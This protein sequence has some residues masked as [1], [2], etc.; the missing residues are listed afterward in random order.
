[1]SRP[2]FSAV[3]Q[4][5]ELFANSCGAGVFSPNVYTNPAA[6]IRA[7]V[8][9]EL[10]KDALNEYAYD[11][12]IS[13]LDYH[14]N[15]QSNGFNLEIDGY[16]D[17]MSVLLEKV[18]TKMRD[19]EVKPDRF[20]VIKDWIRRSYKNW[21]F[22]QPYSQIR[23][24]T[25]YLTTEKYWLNEEHLEELELLTEENIAAFIP[26]ALKQMHFEVLVHG[27]LFK[28]DA[29]KVGL[30]VESVFKP[31]ALPHTQFRERRSLLIPAGSRFIYQHR[32]KDPE[33][34][35]SCI[36]YT[37]WVGEITDR[38]LRAMVNLLSQIT[39]EYGFSF[40]PFFMFEILTHT[41]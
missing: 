41:S 22:A 28:E 18:L 20:K 29:L 11:A 35:N 19:L 36:D 31:R 32:L 14:L 33:N 4:I 30:L 21:D 2:S 10:V 9:C 7:K 3:S 16:N 24:Y 26:E 23:E 13:G 1:M 8:F 27:N 25:K 40:F 39:S 5:R 17:K 34:V 15:A 6:S 37:L 12:E 38:R